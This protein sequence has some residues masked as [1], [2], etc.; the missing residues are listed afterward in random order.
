MSS[1]PK[2]LPQ[3]LLLSTREVSQATGLCEKTVWSETEP[4]GTLRCVRIGR[5]VL[6]DIAD[7]RRWIESKKGGAE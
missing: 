4:R 7:V 6:Y 3:K 2:I 5:R 1:T